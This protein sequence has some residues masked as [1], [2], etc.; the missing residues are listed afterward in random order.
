MFVSFTIPLGCLLAFQA[1]T[2]A[3]TV[4]DPRT[5]TE[6]LA[7]FGPAGDPNTLTIVDRNKLAAFV[8]YALPPAAVKEAYTIF[9]SAIEK[10]RV[11]QQLGAAGANAATKAGLTSLMSFALESGVLTETGAQNAATVHANADGL[12]RFLTN[13]EVVPQCAPADTA[14]QPGWASNLDLSASF[15]GHQFS[16]ATVSYAVA[17]PR[18][19]RSPERRAKWLA[20]FEANHTTPGVAG[21]ELLAYVSSLIAKAQVKDFEGVVADGNAD[22]ASRLARKLDQIIDLLR[23]IDPQFDAKLADLEANFV[24]SISASS[25]AASNPVT[26]P[27]WLAQMTLLE[28]AAAPKVINARIVYAQSPAVTNAVAATGTFTANFGID[29]YETAQCILPNLSRFRDAQAAIEFDRPFGAAGSPATFSIGAYYQYQPRPGILI[30]PGGAEAWANVRGSLLLVQA[31]ITLTAA[32]SG[33]KIP[34]GISWS[35]RT[36]LAQGQ[37]VSGHVGFTFD[38]GGLVLSK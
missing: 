2:A 37:E 38:S 20:W 22:A 21:R 3:I 5:Q 32:S 13:R 36:D 31:G 1:P 27:Q 24:H 34:I 12:M 7:L 6:R 14:C 28:P 35:S 18:D 30:E 10:T 4:N 33:L 29:L 11:D 17:N 26:K 19:I 16:S 25:A 15:T 8:Y 23:Q 9:L